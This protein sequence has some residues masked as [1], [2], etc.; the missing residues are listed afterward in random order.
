MKEVEVEKRI[1]R[2]ILDVYGIT[3]GEL[4]TIESI[5]D[6]NGTSDDND[7][8]FD[9]FSKEMTVDMGGFNYYDFFEEDEFILLNFLRLFKSKKNK[10]KLLL[11]HLKKVA[12]EGKWYEV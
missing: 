10:K 8:F 6:L 2:L 9:R 7:L 3:E 11:T 4:K 5:N 12:I 1:N